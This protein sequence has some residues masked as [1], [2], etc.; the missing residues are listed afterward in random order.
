MNTPHAR[1]LT[2]LDRFNQKVFDAIYGRSLVYNTC[3]EDP[4][5]DRKAL[6][7]GPDDIVLAITSAGC[8]VLDYALLG[9][10]RIHAVDANPRQ[11]ALLELKLAAIRCLDYEDFFA[12]FGRG[13]HDDS[14]RL[15]CNL[16][17]A[18]LSP[19]AREWWD[20]NHL[21][22]SSRRRS[23]YYHGLAGIVARG[24][25][26]YL[27]LRPALAASVHELFS[28]PDI[29][30]QRN[31]YDRRVAEEFWRRGVNWA[32]SR[33]ITMSL[34]GVPHPQRRLVLQQHPGGIAAYIRDAVEYVFRE[35]SIQN[36]YFWLVYVLGHYTEDCCP[37][38]LKRHNFNALKAGLADRIVPHT[39]TVSEFLSDTTERISRFVLLDH[40]D[41]MS[42]YHPN[43]LIEEWNL[44]LERAA[45]NARILFRSAHARPDFLDWI[46]VGASRE[47][48]QDI[49]QFHEELAERLQREDRV[50]TYA[51]FMIAD[52][53]C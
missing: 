26:V 21:W 47:S 28:A 32:L 50:H 22:F 27:K 11:T 6:N 30:A 34:L 4:A 31:I 24:F 53:R 7:L 8:N 35:L 49:L 17:R 29:A 46:Q 20:K 37:E 52:V 10:T 33:R 36:N 44:L 15:Y 48:L 2:L 16:L 13:H 45:P 19:R 9:P 39:C 18:E 42:S 41:S 51:G 5:V 25:H 43:A 23:F 3:W 1:P 12:L 38:Y 40:M 14:A